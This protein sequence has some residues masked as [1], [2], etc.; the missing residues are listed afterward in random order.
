MIKVAVTALG[1]ILAGW[2]GG[3]LAW[4]TVVLVARRQ[5]RPRHGTGPPAIQVATRLL[6]LVGAGL[7][8]PAALER[9]GEGVEGIEAALRRARR[10]GMTAALAGVQGPL[11]PLLRRLG[12]AAASGSPPETTIRTFIES[13]RRQLLTEKVE[14]ARRLPVRLMVPMALL[15]LPGF[16]LMVYGPALISLVAEMLGPLGG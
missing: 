8:L 11:A 15:L 3:L 7:S 1:V 5:S 6:V 9:A 13:E 2:P 12:E 10:I 4:A 16:V 14:R